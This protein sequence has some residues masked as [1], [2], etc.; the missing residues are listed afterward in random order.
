MLLHLVSQK[1]R[2]REHWGRGLRGPGS[3]GLGT[4]SSERHTRAN[5]KRSVL[6]KP[7]TV[8][9]GEERCQGS[10]FLV[11]ACRDVKMAPNDIPSLQLVLRMG[12]V[13]LGQ[14]EWKVGN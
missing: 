2:G 7:G 10:N 6:R 14:E 13:H 3:P 11:S 8:T 5:G 1:P 4:M 9:G 12:C